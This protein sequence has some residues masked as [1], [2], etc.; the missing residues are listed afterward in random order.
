[1][2]LFL[3]KKAYHDFILL[4]KKTEYVLFPKKHND[5]D[6]CKINEKHNMILL[7]KT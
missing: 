5:Y 3:Y 4:I 7:W 6:F 1:M 2:F